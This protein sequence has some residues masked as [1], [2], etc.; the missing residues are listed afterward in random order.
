MVV[1]LAVQNE[2]VGRA[3]DFSWTSGELDRITSLVDRL[4]D[5]K[6]VAEVKTMLIGP[7]VLIILSVELL[8]EHA[9]SI[10]GFIEDNVNLLVEHAP[11]VAC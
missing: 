8:R 4:G 2:T 6:V 7:Q 3:R 11:V 9:V 10:D 5:Q 1:G